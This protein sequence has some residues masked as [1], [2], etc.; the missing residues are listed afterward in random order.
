MTTLREAVEQKLYDNYGYASLSSLH[1]QLNAEYSAGTLNLTSRPTRKA[2]QNI[3]QRQVV[4]QVTTPHS[5]NRYEYNSIVAGPPKPNTIA[6]G[7]PHGVRRSVQMDIMVM[8]NWE[9]ASKYGNGRKSMVGLLALQDVHSRMLFGVPIKD[10]TG[11]TIR[12]VLQHYWDHPDPQTRLRFANLTSDAEKGLLSKEVM[13]FLESKRAQGFERLWISNKGDTASAET[14]AL[15]RLGKWRTQLIERSFRDLRGM[16]RSW[17]AVTGSFR[18]A[19]PPHPP[20]PLVPRLADLEQLLKNDYAGSPIA[21]MIK[22]KNATFHSVLNAKPIEIWTNLKSPRTAP[23][24]TRGSEKGPDGKYKCSWP[25]RTF[26]VRRR[27]NSPAT[28][29][30]GSETNRFAVGDLVRLARTIRVGFDKKSEQ[31][32]WG[33][34]IYKIINEPRVNGDGPH[35]RAR[36]NQGYS[37][38]GAQQIYGDHTRT[39]TRTVMRPSR[40]FLIQ[41]VNQ[42]NDIRDVMAHE[43]L[44]IPRTTRFAK[45]AASPTGEPQYTVQNIPTSFGSD[46]DEIGRFGVGTRANQAR[47]RALRTQREELNELETSATDRI[48]QAAASIPR[49]RQRSTPPPRAAQKRKAPAAR[50]RWAVGDRVSVPWNID[51]DE[52]NEAEVSRFI[53]TVEAVN[54]AKNTI[55]ISYPDTGDELFVQNADDRGLIRLPRR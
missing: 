19:F 29:P 18:W 46:S 30:D 5:V 49:L 41:N 39:G 1:R 12:K 33:R 51:A 32:V 13:S 48:A 21:R 50:P 52:E 55:S 27:N 16:L 24:C 42:N 43:L 37:M 26:G 2:I 47:Q 31:R 53:G 14:Q 10:Y 45:Y 7:L 54:P 11:A 23:A 36:L 25:S 20:F 3:L 34:T 35:T 17:N 9:S 40:R 8:A 28:T 6:P 38:R 15:P 44:K 22:A 4:K